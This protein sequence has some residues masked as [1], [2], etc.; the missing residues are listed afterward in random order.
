MRVLNRA[1]LEKWR[2]RRVEDAYG[3]GVGSESGGEFLSVAVSFP[4]L[5]QSDHGK[6]A[7]IGNPHTQID[8]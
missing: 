6:A 1:S 4:S 2:I 5:C 7:S 8:A 3:G